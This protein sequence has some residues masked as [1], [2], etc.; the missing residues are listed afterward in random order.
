[1]SRSS[2][3]VRAMALLFHTVLMVSHLD[4][5]ILLAQPLVPRWPVDTRQKT[6]QLIRLSLVMCLNFCGTD[7]N[8]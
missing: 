5:D 2:V 1:M 6:I 8:Q 4:R 7:L 3:K